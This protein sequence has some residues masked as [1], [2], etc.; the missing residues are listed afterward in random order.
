[1]PEDVRGLEDRGEESPWCA[2]C[3]QGLKWPG[4]D[5][6]LGCLTE[7][8]RPAET[9]SLRTVHW[10]VAVLQAVMRR[11]VATWEARHP[12]W[13]L[14]PDMQ[15]TWEDSTHPSKYVDP[16]TR[17]GR[18]L[19]WT[20]FRVER[21]HPLGRRDPFR[22]LLLRLRPG[23]ALWDAVLHPRRLQETLRALG[24]PALTPQEMTEHFWA[25]VQA[26]PHV[27]SIVQRRSRAGGG[28]YRR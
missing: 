24:V 13:E 6:C 26:A 19:A 25:K 14:T 12:G 5:E 17:I 23:S 27:E 28:G 2:Q 10:D 21:R 22:G 4:R 1:M 20:R 8:G 16:D 15:R 11:K 7:G 18:K 9:V 3:G